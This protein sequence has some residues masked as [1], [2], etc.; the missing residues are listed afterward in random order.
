MLRFV[1]GVAAGADWDVIVVGSGPAGSSAARAA[2]RAG[3]SV[4][5]LEKAEHPRYKTCGGGL[6]GLSLAN[7]PEGVDLPVHD[8][9]V[10]ATFTRNGAW[11]YTRV[12]PTGPIVSMVS[13][14]EFDHALLRAAVAAGAQV[15]QSA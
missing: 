11:A 2:A 9:V 1:A 13:R 8:Q 15:R 12:S 3:A 10:A 6:V 4:L 5:V 14:E 7:L